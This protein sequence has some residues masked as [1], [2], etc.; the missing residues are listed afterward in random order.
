MT[1]RLTFDSPGI[2]K[3]AIMPVDWLVCFRIL[4]FLNRE[5]RMFHVKEAETER[6]R[7]RKK[8]N[9]CAMKLD[10]DQFRICL[11]VMVTMIWVGKL[12]I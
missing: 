1:T 3:I 11:E 9:V 4:A 12:R 6:E 10:A 2:K 7:E 8:K 5:S